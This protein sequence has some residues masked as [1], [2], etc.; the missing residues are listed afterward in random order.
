MCCPRGHELGV[1]T[2]VGDGVGSAVGAAVGDGVGAGLGEAVGDG[3]G[4]A[5]H[6]VRSA[7]TVCCPSAHAAQEDEPG[8][9]ATMFGAHASH[10]SLVPPAAENWPAAH[11]THV[12][13]MNAANCAGGF[14]RCWPCVQ[15]SGVGVGVGANVGAGV[16][17]GVGLGV[18]TGTHCVCWAAPA[19]CCPSGHVSHDVW[20]SSA[21]C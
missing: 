3:V 12:S 8:C 14:I 4:T 10:A 17:V 2:G 6:F 18:G 5:T 13:G 21:E 9:A 11:G 19:V 1:G 15:T 16:G 7:P 20:P